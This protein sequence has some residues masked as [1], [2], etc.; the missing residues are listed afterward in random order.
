MSKMVIYRKHT[1][2]AGFQLA[3]RRLSQNFSLCRPSILLGTFSSRTD[4]LGARRHGEIFLMDH[5][6]LREKPNAKCSPPSTQKVPMVDPKDCGNQNYRTCS[7]Y[8]ALP[9]D[10]PLKGETKRCGHTNS[11]GKFCIRSKTNEANH[12]A[13]TRI[14][15][16]GEISDDFPDGAP[17]PL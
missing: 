7:A 15:L 16:K 11:E 3:G 1:S 5:Y 12:A 10:N 6:P 8:L 9:L 13:V 17:G 2:R 14:A 4:F